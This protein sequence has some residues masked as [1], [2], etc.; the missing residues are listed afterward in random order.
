MQHFSCAARAWCDLLR[1]QIQGLRGERPPLV[2]AYL[3]V[4]TVTPD[5]GKG[6]INC[7]GGGV[8]AR[9][10]RRRG[11]EMEMTNACGL[12]NTCVTEMRHATWSDGLTI[13]S[14]VIPR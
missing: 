6:E 2:S 7:Y 13:L 3:I 9:K 10:Q 12:S 1:A 8:G 5:R 4:P 14:P 11:Q